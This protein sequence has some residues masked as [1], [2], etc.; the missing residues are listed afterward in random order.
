MYYYHVN[1]EEQDGLRAPIVMKVSKKASDLCAKMG[2]LSNEMAKLDRELLEE[3]A[4]INNTS[5]DEV[6]DI[7]AYNDFL[8]DASQYGTGYI[9]NR[10]VSKGEYEELLKIGLEAGSMWR[11]G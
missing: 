10:Q 2:K 4:R 3:L 5:T 8:V 7:M 6:S 1:S 9:A 11:V